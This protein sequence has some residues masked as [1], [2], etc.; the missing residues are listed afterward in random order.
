MLREFI[1]KRGLDRHHAALVISDGGLRARRLGHGDEVRVVALGAKRVVKFDPDMEETD[2]SPI[3]DRQ[4]RAFGAAGMSWARNP[5]EKPA[6]SEI[7]A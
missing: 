4:V 5:P 3:F 1:Q 6:A 7:A 2:Y